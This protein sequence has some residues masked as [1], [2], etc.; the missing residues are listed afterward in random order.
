VF[1]QLCCSRVL[2]RATP[3]QIDATHAL[4]V[5]TAVAAEL[6]DVEHK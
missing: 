6:R 1:I 3:H 2:T 4:F 5:L